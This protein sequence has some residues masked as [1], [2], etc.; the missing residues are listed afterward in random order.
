MKFDESR[1]AKMLLDRGLLDQFQYQSV[2]DHQSQYGGKFHILAVELGMVPEEK[3][4]RIVAQVTGCQQVSLTKMPPDPQ[5]LSKLPGTFCLERN[6]YPCALRDNAT[7][8]WLAMADPT[9]TKSRTEAQVLSGLKI[10]Q[11]AG[12]PSEIKQALERDYGSKESEAIPFVSGTLDLSEQEEKYEEEFKVTDLSGSTAVKHISQIG[13]PEDDMSRLA[14]AG[15][16][17]DRLLSYQNK[18]ERIL[19]KV[20]E[21]F[22]E[23]GL[24]DAEEMRTRMKK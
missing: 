21:L 18:M 10:R 23:K 2:R 7:T 19:E 8:L 4:T 22:M 24:I 3:M 1:I 16:R 17:L 20:L 13:Q 15:Q 11:L 9:D 14:E 5:A 12:Q 6:V